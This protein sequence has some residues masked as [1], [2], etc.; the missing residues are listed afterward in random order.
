MIFYHSDNSL[1][2]ASLAVDFFFCL[3]GFVIAH[4]YGEKLL[5]KI[6]IKQFIQVRIVRLYPLV[7]LSLA[8]AGPGYMYKAYSTNFLPVADAALILISTLFLIPLGLVYGQQAFPPNNPLWSIFFEIFI[9][10]IYAAAQKFHLNKSVYIAIL[11]TSSILLGYCI[12]ATPGGINLIGFNNYQSFLF[13]F[14]R[15]T[16]PF[17]AGILLYQIKPRVIDGGVFAS[18]LISAS[19]CLMLLNK[20]PIDSYIYD[21]TCSI[22]VIPLIVYFG[23]SVKISGKLSKLFNFFGNISYPLYLLHSPIAKSIKV[24]CEK[25]HIMQ[26]HLFIL[27][28]I[29]LLV[30][31]VLAYAALQL[32]DIPVR[33]WLSDKIK[34]TSP[35]ELSPKNSIQKQT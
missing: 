34:N 11:L 8:I 30:S 5:G 31:I 17:L 28:T 9:N 6:S 26:N 2:H 16:Y 3:S 29:S 10:V 24:A 14:I 21:I 1:P 20:F 22:I 19:L 13:G 12:Y 18:L 7:L 15:V 4:A 33:K 25:L 32:I 27:M 23:C 35:S